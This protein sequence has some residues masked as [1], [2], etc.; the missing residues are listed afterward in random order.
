MLKTLWQF[1]RPHT[2]IGSTV[3]IITL[4]ILNKGDFSADLPILILTLI[5]ALG[6]NVFIT[7]LNQIIDVDLDK[8]NKPTLPLASGTLTL[9]QAWLIVT[10]SCIISLVAAILCSKELLFLILIIMALGIAYSMPPIQLKRH[11]VPAALAITI[12]RGLLVNLGMTYHYAQNL[13]IKYDCIACW[14]NGIDCTMP[15]GAIIPLTIF[16]TAFSLAIAWF[17]DLPDT[18]GDAHFGYQTFPLLYSKRM[19]LYLGTVIVSIAYIYCIYWAWQVDQTILLIGHIILALAFAVNVYF[20]RMGD[21][22]SVK[23]FYMLF[24]VFFF[25]EYVLFGVVRIGR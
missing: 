24:W 7:G 21:A 13:T 10:V 2:I 11:H 25:A 18:A 14:T 23:R 15:Y 1:S 5:A 12:V 6:C 3:S 20:V 8:I 22:A 4:F 19:A 9:R 17:K 16:V